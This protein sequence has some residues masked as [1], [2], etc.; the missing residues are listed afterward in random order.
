MLDFRKAHLNDLPKLLEL[1][2]AVIEAERPFNALTKAV[3]AVYYDLEALISDEDTQLLVIEVEGD[4]IAS[5]Y[6]QIRASKSYLQHNH[7]GYLGFMY[8]APQ[9]RGQGLNKK[10]LDRLIAWGRSQGMN[11]FYLDV[12]TENKAALKAYEKAGFTSG[13]I[14][15][16]LNL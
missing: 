1:E 6:I 4:I 14:E 7:H 12:Y 5:G 16:K 15:M 3:G 13:V 11:D 2:Q 8:V 9:Y 10:M